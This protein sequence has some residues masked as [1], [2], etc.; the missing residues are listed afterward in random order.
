MEYQIKNYRIV[1][2]SKAAKY[3]IARKKLKPKKDISGNA[4]LRRVQHCGIAHTIMNIEAY[5]KGIQNSISYN[6]LI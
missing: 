5:A 6:Q 1:L 4:D 3:S 2:V